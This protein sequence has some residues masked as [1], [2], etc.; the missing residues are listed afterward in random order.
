MINFKTTE[1][2][3]IFVCIKYKELDIKREIDS[4]FEELIG[5]KFV[6]VLW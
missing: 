4:L 3:V 6:E 2:N 1:Y 5:R